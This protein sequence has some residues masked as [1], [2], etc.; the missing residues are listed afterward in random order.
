MGII[1][2]K[3]SEKV[4]DGSKLNVPGQGIMTKKILEPSKIPFK[5]IKTPPPSNTSN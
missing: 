5:D 4:I 1:K 3:K 2:R